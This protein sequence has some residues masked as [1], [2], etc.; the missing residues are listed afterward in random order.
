MTAIPTPG[1]KD[2]QRTRAKQSHSE[3]DFAHLSQSTLPLLVTTVMSPR[4]NVALFKGWQS[5]ILVP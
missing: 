3:S 1:S 4:T 2:Q 5:T